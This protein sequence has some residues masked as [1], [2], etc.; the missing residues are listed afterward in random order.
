M[1]K[2][3]RKRGS[4]RAA[5]GVGTASFGVMTVLG[6]V[7][8]VAIARLYGVSTLGEFALVMAPVNI[9][10]YL[11]SARERPAFV[12]EL[13]TLEPRAP[14]VTGLFAAM[15]TFSFGLTLAVTLLGL[16]VTHLMFDGP[17]DQPELFA[18]AAASLVT[19]LLITNTAWNLDAVFSGFLAARELFWIRL[20]QT[21]A[22]LAL[23]IAFAAL[24]DT[25]W[26]L[27]IA[28]TGS[29]LTSLVHRQIAVRRYMRARVSRAELR[30]GFRTLPE[31][32]KFGLKVTPGSIAN[33]VSNEAGVWVLGVV[34]SVSTVGAY[35][36]AWQ[37]ARRLLEINWRITE[38]LFPTLVERRATG[39]RAGFDRALVDTMRYCAIGMFIPAAVGGGAAHAVMALFGPGFDAAAEGLVLMLP[40]PALFSLAAIQR[41]ALLA[42][43]RPWTSSLV[44]LLRMVVTLALIV[45]LAPSLGITGAAIG[46]L[47]GA[48]ASMVWMSF[49]MAPHLERPMRALWPPREMVAL[50][51]AYAA[52]FGAARAVDSTLDGLLALV[53]ALAAGTVAY[54]AIFWIAGGINARDRDRAT[55]LRSE[56]RGRRARAAAIA[57]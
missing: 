42:V 26:G 41:Q 32:I 34:A 11:S 52:G 47:A 23:S 1:S 50:A 36:R 55:S 44:V 33:G 13:A 3:P 35:D 14:R 12:R 5:L 30:D 40:A 17:I 24:L 37:L 2:A 7:N 25:V 15:M 54:L 4:Y 46:L 56:R 53:P 38:M 57:A 19:Y 21:L 43:D 18:A 29:A 31:M 10:W 9:V 27:V 22:F 45:V 28:T 51:L 16:L 8:A 49:V 20:H 39:D 6:L 48:A